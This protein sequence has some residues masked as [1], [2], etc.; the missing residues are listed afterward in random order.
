MKV[1]IKVSED[2]VCWRNRGRKILCRL[3]YQVTP[4]SDGLCRWFL[5]G[6]EELE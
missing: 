4:Y 6:I 3:S 5:I 2:R 1:R